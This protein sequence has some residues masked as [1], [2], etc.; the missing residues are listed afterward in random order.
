VKLNLVICEADG[1]TYAETFQA[2]YWANTIEQATVEL[3]AFLLQEYGYTPDYKIVSFRY[4]GGF[5]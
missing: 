1:T 4:R 2:P 5:Q 3:E